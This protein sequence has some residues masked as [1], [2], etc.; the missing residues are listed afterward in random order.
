[1]LQMMVTLLE[2]RNAMMETQSNMMDVMMGK[3]NGV[4][5]AKKTLVHQSVIQFAEMELSLMMKLV[6]P[7]RT[8]IV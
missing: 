6:I 4:G 7:S 5:V 3:L 2:L 1:M 8:L